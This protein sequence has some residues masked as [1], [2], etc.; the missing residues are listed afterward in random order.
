MKTFSIIIPVYYN[1]SNL[2]DTI[3]QLLALAEKLTNFHLELVF[4]D[5]GS[6]D[7]SWNILLEFQKKHPQ[8]I[9]I[10]K[11]TRNFGSMAA[12]Q[13]GLKVA[14]GD[15]VGVIA[16]DLQDPPE[17]FLEM[18]KYWE[19]GIKAIFAVR[20]GREESFSQ[21]LFSN[22]YYFLLKKMAIPDYPNGGFDVLL[23][24]RQVVDEL[25]KIN[26]KNTNVFSLVF[27]LGFPY[28]LIPYVRRSRKK[29][30]SRWTLTKKVK[31][32][33]DSFVSFSFV[34]IRFLSVSGLLVA[35]LSFVY[36]LFVIIAWFN[37]KIPVKG[38][39]PLMLVL[40][41]VSGLQITMLG[42]LGEYIWRVLDEVRARPSFVID[43]VVTGDK[44][45]DNDPSDRISE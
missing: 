11:L 44:E 24:D 12:V 22:T 42:V 29:G 45:N 7:H 41:F 32:F 5:D 36:G 43:K 26:E 31:L 21:R 13:A 20:Q 38:Y 10:M 8:I 14:S 3:P 27:W 9:K 28:M 6:G 16:A 37:F 2:P 4:V 23:I 40:S 17:L 30:Q 34:P 1:E 33:I 39:V 25:N 19:N 35:F 18:E 15:C